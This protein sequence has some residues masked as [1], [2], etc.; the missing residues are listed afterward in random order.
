MKFKVTIGICGRNCQDIVEF[1]LESVT[2]Q[3]FSHELMEIVFVDDGSG[4]NTLKT[5]KEYL[6]RID[7]SSRVFSDKWQGLGKARNKIISNALGE[8]IIWVDSDEILTKDFVRKQVTIMEGNP[9]AGIVSGRLGILQDENLMLTLELIPGVVEYSLQDWKGPAKFPGTG[10]ATY[11]VV[12][13]RQVGGFAEEISGIGE[14]I[15]IAS[16]IRDA[17]WQILRGEG[18]F[19]E[20]HGKI[21]NWV[22][23]LRRIV[24]QGV[25]SRQLYRKTDRFYS[26]LKMN[27]FASSITGIRYAVKGYRVTRRKIV[28]LLPPHY[29]VKMLAW[30]YGFS[31]G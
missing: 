30:F 10:G 28:F 15:E 20:K 27:P 24:N 9:K 11:R 21:S 23:Q 3:D 17:G 19:Y 13:A 25:Q 18:V 29:S 12:A 26:L 16:R 14:D 22:N 4:D 1:A 5:V 31:K 2:M 7:I 8:Y 6:S